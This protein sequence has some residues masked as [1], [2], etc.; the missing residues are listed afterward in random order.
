MTQSMTATSSHQHQQYSLNVNEM[1]ASLNS[2]LESSQP[3]TAR[4][5]PDEM[6]RT[7]SL[8]LDE[9]AHIR[10]VLTRAEL[11]GLPLDGNVRENVERGKV[12]SIWFFMW[13]RLI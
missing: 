7:L 4:G 8:G 10:S 6:L 9:V 5:A 3:W 2:E 1:H 13:F 11:E 12:C